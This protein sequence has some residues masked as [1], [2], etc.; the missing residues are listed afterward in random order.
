MMTLYIPKI[1][2]KKYY[3]NKYLVRINLKYFLYFLR[4]N[5]II[6]PMAKHMITVRIPKLL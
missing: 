1:I 6:K 3:G 5:H 4:F 2:I